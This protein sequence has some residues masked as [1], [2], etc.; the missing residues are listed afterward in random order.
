MAKKQGVLIFTAGA[1]AILILDSETAYYGAS[2]G[3]EL[4]LTTV[5]PSLFPFLFMSSLLVGMFPK[6]PGSFLQRATQ[7]LGIPDGICS[8]FLVSL[9]GGYPTGAACIA[10]GYRSGDLEKDTAERML[11]F[12]NNAGPAF[13]FGIA[14]TFFSKKLSF[15]LWMVHILSAIFTFLLLPR[16]YQNIS[17]QAKDTKELSS[18]YVLLQA[19]KSMGAVCGWIVLFRVFIAFCDK[20]FLWLLPEVLQVTV[21]GILELSNGC[22]SLWLI[23]S[24]AVRFL[25]FACFLSFGGLCVA[26]QTKTVAAPL[27][28]HWY[29]VGKSLQCMISTILV[30]LLIPFLFPEENTNPQLIFLLA[31]SAILIFA[32]TRCFQKK[33]VDFPSSVIYTKEKAVKR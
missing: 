7:H 1:L 6:Q 20:W 10:E 28:L 23:S 5:I 4:C 22:C 29:I 18:S 11:G 25:L 32:I 2:Q 3:I 24:P 30:G 26:M 33:T 14:G 13:L 31:V 19:V 12:C 16:N 27:S 9:I 21:Y 8:Y 17:M 15:V